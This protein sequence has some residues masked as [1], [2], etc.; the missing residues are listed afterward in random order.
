M[1]DVKI[2]GIKDSENLAAAIAAG[3]RFVGFVF[4][5]QSP[6]AVTI[7]EAAALAK[8]VPPGV[9]KVGLF[10]NAPNNLLERVLKVVPLDMIQ[11]HGEETPERVEEIKTTFKKPVMKA[12]SVATKYDLEELEAFENAADWLLFDAKNEE[13]IGGTGTSF[14]WSLLQGR[15]FKKP[16]MLAGG[17]TADNVGEALAILNPRTVDVSSG[18]ESAPGEKDAAKI[19]AFIKAVKAA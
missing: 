14:D 2:C 5:P 11:L 15:N 18:V 7:D 13:K 17:L 9:R 3:A 12:I 19:Q 6:R 8:A 16:W 10:V 1:T 4:Y